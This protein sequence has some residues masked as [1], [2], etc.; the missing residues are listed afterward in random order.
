MNDRALIRLLKAVMIS[1]FILIVIGVSLHF[2]AAVAAW[3]VRGIVL[4]AVCVA[5][6][7]ILSLPTKIYLT[8]IMMQRENT[9]P[10]EK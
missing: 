1:G 10:S 9:P 6:G 8:F 7:M 5:L 4:S 2:S 3:G